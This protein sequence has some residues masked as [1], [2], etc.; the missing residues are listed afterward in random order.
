MSASTAF[1]R[2]DFAE[3]SADVGVFWDDFLSALQTWRAMQLR[4]RVTVA[5]AM[6]AFNTTLDV[7][8]NAVSE[9]Y[10]LFLE[11]SG[12]DPSQQTIE[13]EGE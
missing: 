9:A 2:R 11:G 6:L 12:V 5:E 8:L 10:W 4:E 13:L 1:E 3:P 7:V